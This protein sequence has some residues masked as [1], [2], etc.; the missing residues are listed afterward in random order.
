MAALCALLLISVAQDSDPFESR[1][2][3]FRDRLVE[4]GGGSKDTERA[5]QK[6]LEWLAKTQRADHSWEAPEGDYVIG[7]TSLA[8]AA[9]L[10]AGYGP[11]SD[12]AFGEP[13]RRGLKYLLSKQDHEGCVGDRGEKYMYGHA[14]ATLALA[15][16]TGMSTKGEYRKAAQKAVDFLVASRNPGKGW[17]YTAK[18]GD[19]DT[20]VT[21]WAVMALRAAERTG[22]AFLKEHYVGASAWLDEATDPDTGLTGYVGR[23][24]HLRPGP[25][26]AF[27]HHPTTTAMELL[28]RRIIHKTKPHARLKAILPMFLKDLPK[29]EGMA[30]D[31][32]WWH[33]GSQAI[34]ELMAPETDEWKTWNEAMKAAVLKTQVAKGEHAG[35]WEPNDRWSTFVKSRVYA[36]AINALTLET[37]YRYVQRFGAGQK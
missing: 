24:V 7:V 28:S 31:Y 10:G 3:D 21:T 2:S 6:A 9:F 35:S 15:E 13:V 22:P 26:D 37:Y 25:D 16:A 29:A 5:V 1:G 19:N 32:C 34:F 8:V 27:D 23:R 11:E 14:I 18:P 12:T 36:T 20:S 30:V 17:R 4:R 33:F